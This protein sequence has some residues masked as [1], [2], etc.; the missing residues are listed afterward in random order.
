MSTLKEVGKKAL[1]DKSFF[2]ALVANRESLA[3]ALEKY[4][5]LLSKA[6][7]ERLAAALTE[8][9]RQG[10]FS[11]VEFIRRVHKGQ[12]PFIGWD[13]DWD[14]HWIPVHPPH[15]DGV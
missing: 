5:L 14:F 3:P 15:I 2:D 1:E 6:D 9:Q 10:D 11:L 7:L 12:N 4:N 8:P 13:T